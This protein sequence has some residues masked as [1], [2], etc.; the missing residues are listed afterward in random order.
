MSKILLVEDNE[1]NRDMLSRRLIRKGYEVAIA[2]DGAEAIAK[3]E[4]ERPNL[5]LMDL[6]LP[7]LNGWEATRQIKANPQTNAIPIIALTADALAG[8]REKAIAAGCDDYDTKPVDLP[9]LIEKMAKL[10]EPAEPLAAIPQSSKAL[11]PPDNYHTQRRLR[12][13]L[14]QEFEPPIYSIIG[15]SDLLLEALGEALDKQQDLEIP[16]NL[17]GD[18]QKLLTSGKQLLKLIRAILNPALVEIQQQ[19]ID[20]LGPALRR[21]LLTP[22]STIIGYCEILLE[23]AP[24]SFIPDLERIYTSAQDLL[25]KVS[26][27]DNLV[28]QSVESIHTRPADSQTTAKQSPE[29][30]TVSAFSQQAAPANA[31]PLHMEGSRVLMVDNNAYSCAL[32]SRQLESQSLQVSVASTAQQAFQA[33]AAAP[34]DLVLLAID[35]PEASGLEVL[36]K[37]KCPQNGQPV[38]V[39]IVAASDEMEAVVGAIALGAADYLTQPYPLSLLRAKVMHCLAQK[40]LQIQPEDLGDSFESAPLGVY[41]ATAEGRFSRVNSAFVQILGYP[42]GAA[43]IK[44]IA[45]ISIQIYVDS[46]KYAEFKQLLESRDRVTSFEYQAYRYDGDTIWLAEHARAVRDRDGKIVGYEGFVEEITQRKSAEAALTRKLAA[47]Q[48]DLTQ[49]KQAHR[50][51]EIKQTD[52]F[53]Q[54]QRGNQAGSQSSPSPAARASKVLLVEDN[55]LNS[56]MLSRRLK[57]A[58]YEVVIA[59]DGAEGVAKAI[60]QQPDVILMD[61]SLPVMDGW[62]ATQQIKA[63]AQ[64][65]SIP[66]IALTAHAMAG[67]REKALAAGCD[68]YDTKPIDFPRLLNKI[69]NC[70]ERLAAN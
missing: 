70:L 22:L 54:L 67:D 9:R 38:P 33:I 17:H 19:A 30:S 42:A 34:Y 24:E 14:R 51:A 7:V 56:D 57:R 12:T 53:R 26:S 39:L 16:N 65:C 48:D 60:S 27:L 46:S 3:A 66:V 18:L 58:S 50:A 35:L 62:E 41:R 4:S 61:I 6:H 44:A 63:D 47:L 8:E 64:T 25:S 40:R 59:I 43:L 69:E 31:L 37:L 45:D 28:K 13:H 49:V 32:L 55:D 5:I 2:V 15:Y 68:D 20:L 36:A 1:I 21:E 29:L 23:E 11:T 52:Y 10:L